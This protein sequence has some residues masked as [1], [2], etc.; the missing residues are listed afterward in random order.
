[1]CSGVLGTI[2]ALAIG[3]AFS[4]PSQA[5]STAPLIQQTDI[6]YQGAFAL[7]NGNLGSSTFEYGGHGLTV[8]L[9]PSSG[10]ETLFMEGHAQNPG[11]VAQVEV[12][13]S[14]VKSSDQTALPKA[15]VLQNFSTIGNLSSIDP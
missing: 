9:D 1:M 5:Q 8:Y 7:P 4:V 14:F 13:S 15:K 11:N 12:P 2:A 6:V 10:K 3:G